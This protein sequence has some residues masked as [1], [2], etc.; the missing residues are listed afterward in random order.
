MIKKRHTGIDLLRILSMLMIVTLHC[1]VHG[2]LS[3][4]MPAEQPGDAVIWLLRGICTPAV[5]LY[6]LISGYVCSNTKHR[7]ERLAELWIQ[8]WLTSALVGLAFFL[9]GKISL[10]D[11]AMCLLPV[12][13]NRYWYFSAYVLLAVTMPFLLHISSTMPKIAYRNTL[14]ALLLFMCVSGCISSFLGYDAYTVNLGYSFLWLSVMFLTGAYIRNYPEDSFL[15]LKKW[16]YLVCFTVMTMIPLLFRYV[17][18]A[19]PGSAAESIGLQ[20]ILYTYLS[21]TVTIAAISL[22]VF[23]S[24]LQIKSVKWIHTVSAATFGVYLLHDHFAVRT[25]IIEGIC[26]KIAG[27]PVYLMI[28]MVLVFALTVYAICTG[29]DLIRRGVFRFAKIS[30]LVNKT[31]HSIRRILRMEGR[32]ET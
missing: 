30:L 6:A 20:R 8:V 15:Q 27:F 5:N 13:T 9:G 28:P 31:L 16:K 29:I 22:F 14:V 17:V 7:W 24:R 4:L 12:L 25:Y 3:S 23:F 18:F 11:F 19:L 32:K 26:S 21:P 1:I 2:N 10:K